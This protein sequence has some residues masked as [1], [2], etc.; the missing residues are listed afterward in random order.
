MTPPKPG[1]RLPLVLPVH[2]L[3][4]QRPVGFERAAKSSQV[5]DLSHRSLV[6]CAEFV[7]RRALAEC[8]PPSARKPY[9]DFL[10]VVRNWEVQGLAAVKRAR[11]AA[12]E[13]VTTAEEATLSA[14]ARA[15]DAPNGD[16]LDRQ[17][18]LTVRRHAARG[19]H[20]AVATVLMSLD[21][22]TDPTAV[23]SIAEEAAGAIAFTRVALG[24]ARSVE[25][26]ALARERADWEAERLASNE[27][28]P[29]ALAL[30]LFHE[31]LGAHWKDHADARR[32][33]FEEFLDWAFPVTR[34]QPS[35]T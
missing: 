15:V 25:L 34:T 22:V 3:S 1:L 7:A 24:A 28:P 16:A 23:V 21:A 31:Y 33:S 14:L 17:A 19:V 18:A 4:G 29:M 32:A 6:F 27:Q 10:D 8:L 13:G 35:S 12:F 26:R 11:H 2:E 30:Q 5:G 20:H 9:E